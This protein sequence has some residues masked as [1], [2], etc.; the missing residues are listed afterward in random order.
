VPR[1]DASSGVNKFTFLADPTGKRPRQVVPFLPNED[2]AVTRI[3]AIHGASHG[4]SVYLFY[5]RIS[6]LKGVDV[7][8]DFK[9]EG[10]GIAKSESDELQ[11]KRLTAPDGSTD[12]WKSD[13]PTF[14]VFAIRGPEFIY[15]WGSL[16]TGMYLARTRP[17]S[18]EDLASYEYLVEAPTVNDP[19]TSP[20]W[21]KVFN[22]QCVLFDSVP[23]EMSVSYNV[24]LKKYIAFHSFHRENKIVLRTAKRL[25][26]PWGEPQ[27]VYRPT[28]SSADELIYAAK[29]HPELA[30]DGG[31]VLYVTYISSASYIPQLIEVTLS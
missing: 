29:E 18:I 10:M 20:R 11:F 12:F 17:G 23:N 8:L 3:W 7:F 16:A 25:T 21:E 9:L 26:G 22:G 1:Q 6:L 31:R 2:P 28:L 5:H 30:R 14:G 15:L 24:H 4:K 13:L 27:V 19:N